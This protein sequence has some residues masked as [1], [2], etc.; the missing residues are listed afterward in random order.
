MCACFQSCYEEFPT[1]KKKYIYIYIY[2]T[3]KSH[4]LLTTVLSGYYG[5]CKN[6]YVI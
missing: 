6:G 4:M 2:M 3:A 5:R 1:Q